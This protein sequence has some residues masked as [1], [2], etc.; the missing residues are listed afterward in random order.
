VTTA[1]DLAS[2]AAGRKNSFTKW[3]LVF[4]IGLSL[5]ALM[6]TLN[7]WKWGK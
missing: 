6:L 4:T 3:R 5:W 1:T 2:V 7:Y